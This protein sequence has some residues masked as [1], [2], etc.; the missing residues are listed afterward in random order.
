DVCIKWEN[1][2]IKFEDIGVRTVRLRFG[3]VLSEKGGALKK[4]LL[5]TKLGFGSA[6]GSGN[7]FLPWIHIDDLIGIITKSISDE[8]M[9][10]AYNAV[11]PSF[12][13]YNEFAKTMA[14]VMDKPFFMPNVPSLILKLIFGEMSKVILE[15]SK[16]SSK[17]IIDSGYNF[18]FPNLKEALLDLLNNT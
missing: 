8:S 10:G 9:K 17:K 15:G 5:P 2:A 11:A 4:M 3:V 18:I 12:S 13:N 16:I 1:A 7:Q 6:L 14:E